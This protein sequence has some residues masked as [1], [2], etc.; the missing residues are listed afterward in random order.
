MGRKFIKDEAFR[1][2]KP[3]IEDNSL[4]RKKDDRGHHPAVFFMLQDADEMP[5]RE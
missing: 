1:I 2:L 4:L 5:K 3:V